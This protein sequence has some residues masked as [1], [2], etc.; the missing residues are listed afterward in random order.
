MG[1]LEPI[2][3]HTAGD[4]IDD[5]LAAR[6]R[7]RDG[8]KDLFSYRLPGETTSRYFLSQE[9]FAVVFGLGDEYAAAL[10]EVAARTPA[11]QRDRRTR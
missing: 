6:K 7:Y 8:I 3:P 1:A 5:A 11:S 9:Q 10:T 4:A 2:S